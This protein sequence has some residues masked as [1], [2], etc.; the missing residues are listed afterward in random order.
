MSRS[1]TSLPPHAFVACSGT[2]L[3]LAFSILKKIQKDKNKETTEK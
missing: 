1:Y 3:A 2:A